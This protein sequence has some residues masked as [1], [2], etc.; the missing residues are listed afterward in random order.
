[1]S[2]SSSTMS[3]VLIHISGDVAINYHRGHFVVDNT[4]DGFTVLELG[5][6]TFVRNLSTG[7]SSK[8][9][10]KQVTI[11]EGGRIVV[12][13]S[14][15]GIVYVFEESTGTILDV[16]SHEEQGLVQAI[17]VSAPQ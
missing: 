7:I 4:V 5:D 13:G 6:K 11:S 9:L 15:H 17:E 3:R 14:D 2:S 16:L 12:G 8:R 1:V 10:P